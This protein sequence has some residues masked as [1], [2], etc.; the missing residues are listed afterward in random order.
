MRSIKKRVI[1]YALIPV[2]LC[3]G[4]G[5]GGGSSGSSS[6]AT[7]TLSL[8]LT[9][10][11]TTA[12]KAIYVTIDK[13]LVHKNGTSS[14]KSGWFTVATPGQTYNLLELVNGLTAILGECELEAGRYRQIRLMIGMVPES[15][16]NILGLAHPYANYIILNDGADTVEKLKIPSGFRSGLKLVH[17]FQVPAGAVVEL[18]LDFDA[19]RSVVRTGSG[20]YRLKPTIKVIDTNNKSFV[21]GAV[22][23][24]D[25]GQPITGALVSAQVS[26]GL[27]ATVVRS[28]LTS[29]DALDEGRF[30]LILSPG[31]EYNIVAF[32]D[33]KVVAEDLQEMYAPACGGIT[34]PD[35]GN[36][37]L[38][39]RLART[40]FGTITGDVSVGG[41]VDPDNPPVVYIQFYRLLDCGYVQITSLPVSPDA[42]T[43]IISFSVDLPLGTYDVVA[44]SEGLAPD[45]ASSQELSVPGDT[46]QVSLTL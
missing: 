11:S 25:T 18:V 20:R 44:S 34:I 29:D 13:V 43:Q 27:S 40:N 31:K 33:Q 19:C 17:S 32:S 5:G 45:T 7:G 15:A 46:I 1:V 21:S 35:Y 8:S 3:F 42:D 26:D 22:A 9:D 24:S 39:V 10:A 30:S 23:D 41:T 38:D 12:F 36:T 14:G 4:C 28:T 37:W 6:P 2:I 16:N